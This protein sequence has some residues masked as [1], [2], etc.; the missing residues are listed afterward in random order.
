MAEASQNTRYTTI[1]KKG[2]WSFLQRSNGSEGAYHQC[3][4]FEALHKQK[5]SYPV[6]Y[7]DVVSTKTSSRRVQPAFRCGACNKRAP[8]SIITLLIKKGDTNV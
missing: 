5:V 2:R 1:M 3:L 6:V 7:C 8:K 4:R